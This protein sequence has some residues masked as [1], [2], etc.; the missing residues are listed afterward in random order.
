MDEVEVELANGSTVISNPKGEVVIDT[1]K[2]EVTSG[3]VVY[4]LFLQLNILSCSVLDEHGITAVISVGVGNFINSECSNKC[5]ENIPRRVNDSLHTV[6]VIR[7]KEKPSTK[8][9]STASAGRPASKMACTPRTVFG[10]GGW[11]MPPKQLWSIRL[12][13]L[14]ME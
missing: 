13:T 1:G 6:K 12:G 4:I 7:P 3:T 2:K 11:D 10:I 8:N 9:Y 5:P 14:L